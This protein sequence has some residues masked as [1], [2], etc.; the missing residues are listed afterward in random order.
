LRFYEGMVGCELPG[1]EDKPSSFLRPKKLI[2]HNAGIGVRT[3]SFV[4]YDDR[5]GLTLLQE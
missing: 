2:L 1:K 5:A 4:R 3:A